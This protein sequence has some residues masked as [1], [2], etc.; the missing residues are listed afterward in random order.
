MAGRRTEADAIIGYLVKEAESRG[1]LSR[2]SHVFTPQHKSVRKKLKQSLLRF[3]GNMLYSFRKPNYLLEK[4]SSRQMQLTELSIKSQN[5]F[6]QHYIDGE[7]M[8]SFFDYDIH[9]EDVWQKRL[10]D[11]SSRPF[12]REELADYLSSYHEKFHSAAMQASIE[13]LRDPK[14]QRL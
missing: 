9:S 13:K 3:S 7:N 4:G 11:L 5:K 2:S 8:S 1:L 10:H 14:A 6:V 12:A